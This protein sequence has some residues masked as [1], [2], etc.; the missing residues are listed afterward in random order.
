MNLK[1]PKKIIIKNFLLRKPKLSDSKKVFLEYASDINVAFYTTWEPHKNEN[2][3]KIFLKKILE[4]WNMNKEFNFIIEKKE[5]NNFIGFLKIKFIKRN[6]I[7]VGYAIAKKNWGKGYMTEILKEIINFLFKNK[8][9]DEIQAFC[10]IENKASEKVLIKSGMKFLKLLKK[11]I[12]HPN[13][14]KIKKRDCLLYKIENF[15]GD[16]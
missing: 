13:I 5:N 16:K 6:K 8:F 3:T 12:I 7:Q 1:L 14:S 10:D 11:H 4:K 2:E 9:A 15:Y